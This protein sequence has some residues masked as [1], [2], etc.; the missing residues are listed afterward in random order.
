MRLP[1]EG[2]SSRLRGFGYA[3]FPSIND[4]MEALNLKG[5]VRGTAILLV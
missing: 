3:E 2:G 4:L 5:E 1:T